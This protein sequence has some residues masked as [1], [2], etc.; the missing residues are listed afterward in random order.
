[1]LSSFNYYTPRINVEV[2]TNQ[3]DWYSASAEVITSQEE[4]ASYLE[5]YLEAYP[6]SRIGDTEINFEKYQIISFCCAV[7][8]GGWRIGDLRITEYCDKVVFNLYLVSP[9]VITNSRIDTV[10]V[11]VKI[12]ITAK[13]IEY[14]I[15]IK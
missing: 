10:S 9:K 13:S 8:T 1:M 7:N 11:I 5:Y 2:I 3:K 14:E 15:S 12:P 6:E 4:W